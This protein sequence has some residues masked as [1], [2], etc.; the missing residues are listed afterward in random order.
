VLRENLATVDPYRFEDIVR[1]LLEAMGYEDV[2]VTAQSGDKEVDIV[3]T[4]QFGITTFREVI[5]VKRHQA[6]IGRPPA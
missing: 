1:Q 6:S 3:A 4:T 5:Q 2:E